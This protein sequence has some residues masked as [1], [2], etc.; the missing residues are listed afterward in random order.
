MAGALGPAGSNQQIPLANTFKPGEQRI[1]DESQRGRNPEQA[2]E[3]NNGVTTT[4]ET[5]KSSEVSAVRQS[6]QGGSVSARSAE[7]GKTQGST[8]RGSLLNVVV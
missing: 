8:A 2:R 6:Q 1:Q 5:V 4:R 3:Q 7:S